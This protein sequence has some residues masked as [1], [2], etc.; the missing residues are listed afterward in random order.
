MIIDDRLRV[1]VRAVLL[2]VRVS[3][4]R[5]ISRKRRKSF[6]KI[7][8]DCTQERRRT[9]R[10]EEARRKDAAVRGTGTEVYRH[11]ELQSV[12][13]WLLLRPPTTRLVTT[14][15]NA[16]GSVQCYA[17]V[18]C[19]LVHCQSTYRAP[20]VVH[21]SC[22]SDSPDFRYSSFFVHR[23]STYRALSV[24]D[25]AAAVL[26]F[27]IY[28]TLGLFDV[29]CSLS[30]VH[31]FLIRCKKYCYCIYYRFL[32][33]RFMHIIDLVSFLVGFS[34]EYKIRCMSNLRKNAVRCNICTCSNTLCSIL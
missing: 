2:L 11:S 10:E 18:L 23:R 5:L 27:W 25:S 21:F 14:T 15:I 20:S 33:Y 24:V 9:K 26:S 1:L 34:Y 22:A 6:W 8:K 4:T 19:L 28:F 32:Y 17:S 12:C 31:C 30:F 16:S 3:L 7:T 13:H 29:S